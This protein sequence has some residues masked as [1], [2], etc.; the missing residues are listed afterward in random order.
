MRE[1]REV[2]VQTGG[3]VISVCVD[4]DTHTGDSNAEI[5]IEKLFWSLQKLSGNEIVKEIL[6][7]GDV[8][9]FE[10][11]DGR[12]FCGYRSRLSR[13]KAKGELAMTGVTRFLFF[14]IILVV[15]MG[16][17]EAVGLHMKDYWTVAEFISEHPE[18]VAK[19][20]AMAEIVASPGLPFEGTQEAPV[21][22]MVVYPGLQASDYWRRSVSSFERR[23]D[24]LN[25]DYEIESFFTKP[26]TDIALQSD[27]IGEAL[28]TAPDYL[29]FT[30][31]VQRHQGLIERIMAR[32]KTKVIV[33][34]I[35]TPLREFG[36]QQPFLYVGFDHFI[37]TEILAERYMADIPE[38]EYALFYGPRGYVSTARGETFRLRLAEK[39]GY[40]LKA[41]FYVGFDRERSYNAALEVLAENPDLKFFYACSTD[42]ALGIIDALKEMGKTETITVNGW[43]G[44]SPE[45][46]AIDAGELAFTVMRMNDDNGVVMAEAIKMDLEGRADQVPQI[47]S[48]AF[49]I[50]DQFT[51]P[52]Q[53][54]EY[55]SYSFRYSD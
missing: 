36:E 51:T 1:G 18:E 38:G 20:D 4:R 17:S 44:G 9:F 22:I 30:L 28:E 13:S 29:I 24:E 21:R 40:D 2:L 32:G 52:E 14:P 34:N 54:N 8:W 23:M 11:P 55:Q 35:T 37:G 12:I 26:G 50:V 27:L 43:G 19:Q 31:D 16:V 5:P 10:V 39:S 33:Q 7:N 46:A 6:A 45:L 41:S 48:G 3:N 25:I 53:L 49:K 47:F 42:I 15:A